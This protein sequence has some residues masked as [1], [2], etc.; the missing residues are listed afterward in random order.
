M[1]TIRG[2][3]GVKALVGQEVAISGWFQVT[4]QGIDSFSRVTGA[5]QFIRGGPDLADEKPFGPAV[6]PGYY[7]LALL[8][9]FSYETLAYEGFDLGVNYGL[10][11]VRFPAP[12]GV[13]AS[14]R[15]RATIDAVKEVPGG[16]QV[17]RTVTLE[18][19]HG[20][21]PVCVAESLTRLYGSADRSKG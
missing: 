5:E 17:T 16:I 12:L 2:T 14:V 4:Q 20:G 21:E 1:R 7:L 8:P 10:N 6:A 18:A 3:D 9:R 15:M 19:D 13:G 11:R